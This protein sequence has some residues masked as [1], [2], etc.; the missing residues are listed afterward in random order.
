MVGGSSVS[1][2]LGQTLDRVPVLGEHGSHPTVVVHNPAL[3]GRSVGVHNPALTGEG[4]T[5]PP[6]PEGE[7]VLVPGVGG[8]APQNN[9]RLINSGSSDLNQRLA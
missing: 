9:F 2:G 7:S 5:H 3:L 4:G 8:N 6:T 1:L